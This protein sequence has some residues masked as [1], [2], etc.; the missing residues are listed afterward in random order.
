MSSKDHEQLELQFLG[1]HELKNVSGTVPVYSARAFFV[2]Q[3]AGAPVG[4]VG[5]ETFSPDSCCCRRNRTAG[6]VL[7][8]RRPYGQEKRA[9]VSLATFHCRAAPSPAA[10]I[11][12]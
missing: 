8:H 1:D 7:V 12:R 9:A 3:N 6:G 5:T 11:R 2:I 4:D 10:T